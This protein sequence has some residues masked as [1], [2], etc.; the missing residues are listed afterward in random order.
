MKKHLF[1]TISFLLLTAATWWGMS[2][3]K[4]KSPDTINTL[5]YSLTSNPQGESYEKWSQHWWTWL[6]NQHCPNNAFADTTGAYANLDQSGTVYFLAGSPKVGVVRNVTIPGGKDL[7]FPVMNYINDFPCP[8]TA[9]H[10]VPGETLE[11]F[12]Q[13]AAKDGMDRVSGVQVNLDDVALTN[14]ASYRV[15]TSLYYFTGNPEMTACFDPCIT[16]TSQAAVSDGYWFMLRALPKGTHKLHFH[17]EVTAWNWVQDVTYN[18]TV[19]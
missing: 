11:H 14:A 19:E 17:G 9:F 13:A 7:F 12:L 10:P 3:K 6:L 5:V 2:C 4:D 15:A 8:D 18:L 1:R 16:G